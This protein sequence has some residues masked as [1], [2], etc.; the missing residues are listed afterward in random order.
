MATPTMVPVELYLHS[1]AEYE[2]DAEYVDG[3]I[4]LRPMGEYDH[5]TWQ[6]AIERWFLGHLKDW[7]IRV[8]VELRVRVSPTRYRVPDVVVFDR[9]QPVE[10]ILTKS[11]IA[12]FEVLSPE[13]RMSRV[14][15]KLGDYEA[16]GI[17]A[18]RVIDPATGAIFRYE[19]GRLESVVVT[20]EQLAGSRCSIDWDQVRALLDA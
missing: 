1:P 13:D 6:Q 19:S 17:P 5:S 20:A 8:R 10:Q 15:V 3:E 18:I 16:M 4:E 12:V 2:P 14:M 11:P 9:D 7:N